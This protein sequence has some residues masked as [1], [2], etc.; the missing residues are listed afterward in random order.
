MVGLI[1]GVSEGLGPVGGA[2]AIYSLSGLLLI[3]T[4]GFPRIRQIPKG[5]LLAGCLL[6]VSYEICLALSL[7]Y[8]ATRHQAIEVGMVNYLWPSLTILFAIL[9]NGQKTNWLIVPG[10]LLALVG[11]CWVLGGD[12]GLHYDEIINNITTSPLSYFLAFIGAFI[13]AA[14]CTVTNKYARGFNGIT[15]FVLLTGASLWVYYFLTPQPEMVFS[16]PVMIKLISAAFTLG[17]AYAAWNVGILTW[18]RHHYGGRFVFYARPF[19]SA[20]SR[21]AQR[22]AVV[23][24]LARRANGLRRFPAL[25]A[26][27]TSWLK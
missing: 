25:L 14:Y 18:Q 22:P 27:D 4:V 26:G 2:A 9:F 13:W 10:L 6:F 11:V 24:V 16:T 8:A 20:C 19:L 12:N 7:G 23:L 17:F 15:V 5:Y 3:F 21:A 1:R